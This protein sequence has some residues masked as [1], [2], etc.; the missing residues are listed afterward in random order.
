MIDRTRAKSPPEAFLA[1]FV[2]LA[3][4]SPGKRIC[5]KAT[6][7]VLLPGVML[8]VVAELHLRLEYHLTVLAFVF[9]PMARLRTEDTGVVDWVSHVV[10]FLGLIIIIDY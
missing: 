2:L 7:E 8:R 9:G 5:T 3:H 4:R 6:G 10:G 1:N